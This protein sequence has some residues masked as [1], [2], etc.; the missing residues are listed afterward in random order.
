[1]FIDKLIVIRYVMKNK[2]NNY[3]IHCNNNEYY[4][5]YSLYEKHI[6]L[7][8][9]NQKTLISKHDIIF[10]FLSL[11]IC[12]LLHNGCLVCYKSF[13]HSKKYCNITYHN[14]CCCKFVNTCNS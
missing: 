3:N 10:W 2:I 4:N 6:L 1:M 8:K 7:N 11:F 5:I 13:I 14:Y 12:M 9:I